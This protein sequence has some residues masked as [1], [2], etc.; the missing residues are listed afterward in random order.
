MKGALEQFL[1]AVDCLLVISAPL[2]AN[3]IQSQ[4][5]ENRKVRLRQIVKKDNQE[6]CV[7]C[8]KTNNTRCILQHISYS[9][10]WHNINRNRDIFL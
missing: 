2:Y 10:V 6:F 7:H 3:F 8:W 1:F 9:P 4:K 5:K